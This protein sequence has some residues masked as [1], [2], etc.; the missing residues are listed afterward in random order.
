MISEDPEA[1]AAEWVIRLGNAEL[2]AQAQAEEEAAFQAWI[3]R[4]PLQRA[5]FERAQA[6]WHELGL[7]TASD[8]SDDPQEEVRTPQMA[9]Q[10]WTHA[11]GRRFAQTILA[12]SCMILMA[13]VGTVFWY[14]NPFV[15][16]QADYVAGRG[17]MKVVELPDGS[18]VELASDSAIKLAF[19]QDERHIDL[20]R[21]TAYFIV[22]PMTEAEP[23]PF[24]VMAEGMETTAL[25]TQFM[26]EI[27]PDDMSVLVTEHSVRVAAGTD[28]VTLAED[29]KVHFEPDTGFSQIETG[30][31]EFETAWR[32]GLL[33]FDDQPLSEVVRELNRYRHG[34]IVIRNEEL[35]ARRV[36]GVF[37]IKKIGQAVD[38]IASDLDLSVFQI[39]PMVTVIY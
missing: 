21:G 3:N 6:L 18:Q 26:V 15:L 19:N 17:D 22:S 1:E 27:T 38:R 9:A 16:M 4:G 25:G 11:H 14:G 33:I 32:R 28:Q 8:L 31:S 5:A 20:L 34:K 23:R 24:T 2:S 13:V 12:L 7:L 35:A 39:P 36:S 29:H 30:T 37:D 10:A